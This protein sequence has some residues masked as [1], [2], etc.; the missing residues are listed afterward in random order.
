MSTLLV[1]NIE[2][3]AT[4]DD[5]RRE[6]KDGAMYVRNNVIEAVGTTVEI[7]ARQADQTLDLS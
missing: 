1:K 6:I 7:G 2:L 5:G 4:F 3:L